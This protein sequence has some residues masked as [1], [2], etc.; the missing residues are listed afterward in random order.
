MEQTLGFVDGCEITVEASPETLTRRTICTLLDCGVTR[1]SIGVQTFDNHLLGDVCKRR[2]TA[3]QATRAIGV[4]KAEGFENINIDLIYGLPDQNVESWEHTL[5]AA[6]ECRPASVS[7]YHLRIHPQTPMAKLASCEPS[8]FPSEQDNM[9]M[10]TM[11]VEKLEMV[12][13][14]RQFANKFTLSE[15]HLHRQL[16]DKRSRE[17]ELLGIGASSYSYLNHRVYY[18]HPDIQRYVDAI[19]NGELPAWRGRRLSEAD[20]MIRLT[21]LSLKSPNGLDKQVFER[22]FGRP[23][24]SVFGQL[25]TKLNDL[26]L[27][28]CDN[29]TIKLSDRGMLVVDEVCRK[30]YTDQDNALLGDQDEAGYGMFLPEVDPSQQ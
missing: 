23:V 12:G 19:G 10:Y 29:R 7:V 6:C 22:T 15:D 30:F 24:E 13:Y 5:E 9:V 21:I 20:R 2:H 16:I 11:A 8:R 4:A 28:K 17:G 1:L 3:E 25:V 26:R 18:N 27:L 14:R